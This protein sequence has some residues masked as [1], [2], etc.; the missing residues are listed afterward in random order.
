ILFSNATKAPADLKGK[1]VAYGQGTVMEF[2]LSVVLGKAGLSLKDVETVNM[3]GGDAGSAFSTG[4]VDAA[5]TWDPYLSKGAKSG[6]GYKY[7]DT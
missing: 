6:Y 5:V 7:T 3:T 1:S 2:F 4:Q